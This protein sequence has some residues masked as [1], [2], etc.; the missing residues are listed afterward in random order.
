VSAAEI[1][2]LRARVDACVRVLVRAYE[3]EGLPVPPDL[4]GEAVRAG[5]YQAAAAASRRPRHRARHGLRLVPP[6]G[7]AW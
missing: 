7:G 6:A 5:Q 2:E 3:A 1:A 4:G